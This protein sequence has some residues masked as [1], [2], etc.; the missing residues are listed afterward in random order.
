MQLY[1]MKRDGHSLP[2]SSVVLMSVAVVYKLVLVLI[3]IG[4]LIFWNVPLKGY[5]QEYYGLYFLGLFLNTALVAM[6]LLVMFSPGIIRRLFYK[7]DRIMIRFRL[8]KASYTRREKMERFISGYQGTVR[9]LRDNKK[10]IRIV[11]IGTF[12]Q[13]FM[14]FVLTFA[15]YRGLGLSGTGL[16]DIVFVQASVYIAV[17]ML[18]VPGSQGITE[19]MYASVFGSIFT[20]KYLVASMC[21]TR[22]ISFYALMG[23]GL[24]VFCTANIRKSGQ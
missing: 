1:Y 20:G 6:L 2:A 9:F 19:A 8:W 3:G 14:V 17:D 23:L 15:V 7:A 21:I 12:L 24:L 5:L 18:P 10:I 11:L 16:F 13:R 4:I 22:G